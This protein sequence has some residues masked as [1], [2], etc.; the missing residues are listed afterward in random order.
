MVIQNKKEDVILFSINFIYF[1]FLKSYMNQF[2]DEF[3]YLPFYTFEQYLIFCLVIYSLLNILLNK[4]ALLVPSFLA[5]YLK[6]SFT[7][8]GISKLTFG[9]YLT[10]SLNN[11]SRKLL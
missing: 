4:N 5:L 10:S 2:F 9:I 7:T 1:S 6:Y 8:S 3:F 11:C